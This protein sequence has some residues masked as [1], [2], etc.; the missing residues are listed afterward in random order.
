MTLNIRLAT[1]GDVPGIA[2]LE[3]RH[4]V[5]NLDPAE[6]ADGFISVLHSPKWFAGAV[7]AGGL[8][9]AVTADD[10]VVGFIAV[11]APPDPST[12]G[13][14]EIVRAMLDLAETLEMNGRPIARQRFALR[15][16]VC[17]DKAA[18]G[19]GAYSAFNSVTRQAYRDRFD[20]GVLFVAA[21][22]PRSLH[23]TTAKLGAIPLAEF[24]VDRRRFHFLAY[25]FGDRD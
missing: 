23:T 4:Y 19:R 1:A 2:A 25:E 18:R 10:G 11:T 5:G 16:P 24:E 22:N 8:H 3:A 17:I 7:D 9:V 21:G 14:P 13:L 12:A 20:V 15:G 6:Q